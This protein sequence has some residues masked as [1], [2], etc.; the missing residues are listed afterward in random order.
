[1]Y[2]MMEAFGYSMSV[3][4]LGPL[5][6]IRFGDRTRRLRRETAEYSRGALVLH[7]T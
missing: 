7:I 3:D 5:A 6:N 2:T 1:M 4:L